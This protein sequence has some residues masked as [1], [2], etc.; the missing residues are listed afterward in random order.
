MAQQTCQHESCDAD[1]DCIV[2][3]TT[4]GPITGEY[5]THESSPLC[6]G[7]TVSAQMDYKDAKH[8]D[9]EIQPA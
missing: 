3:V 5:R 8:A 2:T 4:V 7:C 1:A 9:L 6:R